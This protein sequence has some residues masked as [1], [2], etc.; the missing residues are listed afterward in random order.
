M[1][2]GWQLRLADS[3]TQEAI[4]RCEALCPLPTNRQGA[5]VGSLEDLCRD[6]MGS[7]RFFDSKMKKHFNARYLIGRI[8]THEGHSRAVP[9]EWLQDKRLGLAKLWKLLSRETTAVSLPPATQLIASN[10]SLAAEPITAP[11]VPTAVEATPDTLQYTDLRR[12]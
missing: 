2:A 8:L 3:A 1:S 12:K 11:A 4:A 7:A 5:K 10:T 6:F 9:L